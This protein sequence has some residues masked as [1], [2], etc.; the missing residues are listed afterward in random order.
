MGRRAAQRG[1]AGRGRG[2]VG[3]TRRGD[4]DRSEIESLRDTHAATLSLTVRLAREE[5]TQNTLVG[6]K[7]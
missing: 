1:R 7:M 2:K 4:E 6:G 5:L 3:R